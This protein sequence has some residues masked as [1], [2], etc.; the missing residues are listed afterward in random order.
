MTK[1]YGQ[2]KLAK[3]VPELLSELLQAKIDLAWEKRESS[4]EYEKAANCIIERHS[5]R[6]STIKYYLA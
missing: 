1:T 2:V 3:I 4:E 5:K 6:E